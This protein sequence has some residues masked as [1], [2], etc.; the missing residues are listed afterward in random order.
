[1]GILGMV[2]DVRSVIFVA[3]VPA[4]FKSQSHSHS[5]HFPVVDA[6]AA[7]AAGAPKTKLY[8]LLRTYVCCLS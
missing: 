3:A 5:Q 4:A 2:V 8:H 1:M 6:C 7:A